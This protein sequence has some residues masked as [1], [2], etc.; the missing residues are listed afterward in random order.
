MNR[1]FKL[2]SKFNERKI[3]INNIYVT[4]NLRIITY[5]TVDYLNSYLKE[6]I[7]II[8]NPVI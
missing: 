1:F 7:I 4:R 3:V 8:V 2:Q 5:V 6:W